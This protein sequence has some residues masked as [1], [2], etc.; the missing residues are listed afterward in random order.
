MA[1]WRADGFDVGKKHWH[2]DAVHL[3][4]QRHH[5]IT[6]LLWIFLQAHIIAAWTL[7]D[8]LCIIREK[9]N[10]VGKEQ[11]TEMINNKPEIDG[12]QTNNNVEKLQNSIKSNQYSGDL[13]KVDS[14]DAAADALA[15]RIGGKSRVKFSNDPSA[16]EFDV[17]SDKYIAQAKPDLK[18]YGKS[19]RKQTKAT[20]EAAKQT[21]KIPYFQFEG[22]PSPDI[23]KKIQEYSERYGIDYVIDTKPL[24]VKN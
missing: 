11:T 19:W 16:R 12:T 13:I 3:T 10:T 4:G 24:G 8:R 14:P 21:D 7:R 20:F 22:E 2:N 15:E 18:G 9:N 17:I 6:V 23:I 5:I 1:T